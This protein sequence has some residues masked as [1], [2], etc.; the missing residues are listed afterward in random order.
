MLVPAS[1]KRER[2][3]STMGMGQRRRWR[4]RV[5]RVA[6]AVGAAAVGVLLVAAPASA[7]VVNIYDS[8]HVLD[9][10]RVQNAAAVL[11]DPVSVYTTTKAADDNAA[12][13]REAQ[14]HVT[15]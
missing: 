10:T 8:S 15:A 7:D 5:A 4:R 11:P 2:S 14:S 12:F 13:D 3:A 6:V 1:S 9:A